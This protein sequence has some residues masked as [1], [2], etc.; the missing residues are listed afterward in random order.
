MKKQ[1]SSLV[2]CLA[3]VALLIAG[4]Q[5][6][7]PAPD[8]AYVAGIYY[9]Q[10]LDPSMNGC[11]TFDYLQFWPDGMLTYV[12]ITPEDT[13]MDAV[14]AYNEI[15]ISWLEPFGVPGHTG[16]YVILGDRITLNYSAHEAWPAEQ[17][18][19]QYQPPTVIVFAT[20]GE[21]W[22]YAPLTP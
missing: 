9:R 12:T 11:T 15:A 6:C 13:T 7:P 19:G 5:P 17:L 20:G 8:P 22:E 4:C 3:V 21:T 1:I 14:Q 10:W 18:T 2:T 16:N